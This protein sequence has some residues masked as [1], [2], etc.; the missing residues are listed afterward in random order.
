MGTRTYSR[1]RADGT[2]VLTA[3]GRARA[4][5]VG[6]DEFSTYDDYLRPPRGGVT[7]ET[8]DQAIDRQLSKLLDIGRSLGINN[9]LDETLPAGVKPFNFNTVD[10]RDFTDNIEGQLIPFATSPVN[11]GP[12][13]DGDRVNRSGARVDKGVNFAITLNR[14]AQ[15]AYRD[16]FVAINTAVDAALA[17]AEASGDT[18]EAENLRTLGALVRPAIGD[19]SSTAA[20]SGVVFTGKRNG[21]RVVESRPSYAS[22]LGERIQ[23]AIT[24]GGGERLWPRSS[25]TSTEQ[26]VRLGEALGNAL[27]ALRMGEQSALRTRAR[28]TARA[29]G[30]RQ[31]A[32]V[33]P[34]YSDEYNMRRASIWSEPVS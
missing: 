23:A 9:S 12:S 27:T 13:A 31:D 19:L 16:A 3:L 1:R 17:R 2:R 32:G 28:M 34:A 30:I 21:Q 4:G 11:L 14:R 6:S 24:G 26:G 20:F 22:V 33:R 8:P 7:N 29:R 15:N 18:A 5:G 25:D 10:G